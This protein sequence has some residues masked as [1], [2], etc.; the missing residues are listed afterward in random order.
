MNF[1]SLG[2]YLTTLSGAAFLLTV[3]ESRRQRAARGETPEQVA[4]RDEEAVS[5]FREILRDVRRDDISSIMTHGGASTV[6]IALQTLNESPSGAQIAQ[7]ILNVY[8]TVRAFGAFQ[9]AM[10]SSPL[11]ALA[12][13]SFG[14]PMFGATSTTTSQTTLPPTVTTL[15]NQLEAIGFDLNAIPEQFK[16]SITNSI[17]DDPVSAKT[18]V[19][20]NGVAVEAN[21]VYDR[22]TF[23]RLNGVC[24]QNRQPF[25][26]V[27]AKPELQ[28]QIR[29][30]VN[31][32]VKEY[33]ERMS[34]G[35]QSSTSSTTPR[36]G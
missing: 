3:L 13:S 23:D 26:E 28:N 10:Q 29:Q 22:S 21:Y 5:T 25:L 17:M 6:G 14:F 24:P 20:A 18:I 1:R 35:N 36:F 32:K 33:G 30:F 34:N 31:Q 12:G 11:A 2:A 16:D 15:H 4:Q 9:S 19:N 27:T 8:N 7:P